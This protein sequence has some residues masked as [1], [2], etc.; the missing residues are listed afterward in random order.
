MP[1]KTRKP[2]PSK[3]KARPVPAA[4]TEGLPQPQ[5]ATHGKISRLALQVRR[6]TALDEAAKRSRR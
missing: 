4:S 1:S 3:A 2:A 6:L 5:F